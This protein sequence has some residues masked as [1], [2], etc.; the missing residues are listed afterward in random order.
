MSTLLLHLHGNKLLNKTLLPPQLF[1]YDELII[2]RKRYIL[3]QKEVT[4]SYNQISQIT[5]NRGIFFASLDIMTSG[6]DD[7]VIR[8]LNKH[9]AAKAKKIID[10][11][12][13]YSHAKHHDDAEKSKATPTHVEKSLTR[14]KELLHQGT[15]TDRE[16]KEKRKK[17][18]SG[19]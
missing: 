1:I 5:M 2:F 10:Q 6:T 12:I 11:K 16:Y 3:S 17:V 19:L 7:V 4:I 15:I 13:Y 8:F 9:L 18:L 14:L